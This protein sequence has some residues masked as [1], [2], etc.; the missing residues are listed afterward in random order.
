M[1]WCKKTWIANQNKICPKLALEDTGDGSVSSTPVSYRDDHETHP[2]MNSL[3]DP[4]N[5]TLSLNCA[6][7]PT[8]RVLQM[9][10]THLLL[11]FI[12]HPLT[13]IISFFWTWS[14]NSSRPSNVSRSHLLVCCR[15][16]FNTNHHNQWRQ[17]YI[18]MTNCSFVNM[19]SLMHHPHQ[20]HYHKTSHTQAR[21]APLSVSLVHHTDIEDAECNGM[22]N[23]LNP[24]TIIV[25]GHRPNVTLD[26][27][28]VH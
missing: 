23:H 17:P 12:H 26:R 10:F 27:K 16:R 28:Q 1:P 9:F 13:E 20:Q 8:W 15:E 11:S 6:N 18:Q 5:S 4:P 3:L 24:M 19:N 22:V 7:N 14:R 2:M 25:V 21:R